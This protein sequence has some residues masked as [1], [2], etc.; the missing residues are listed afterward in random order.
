MLS[1]DK[2]IHYLLTCVWVL[3]LTQDIRAQ[4]SDSEYT[5]KLNFLKE[6]SKGILADYS[7]RKEKFEKNFNEQLKAF[8]NS[9]EDLAKKRFFMEE[10]RQKRTQLLESFKSDMAL[11]NE[12]EAELRAMRTPSDESGPTP[13]ELK[14]Q[15]QSQLIQ[16]RKSM[17]DFSE[18]IR[19]QEEAIQAENKKMGPEKEQGINQDDSVQSPP[20]AKPKDVP[21]EIQPKVIIPVNNPSTSTKKKY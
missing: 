18:R 3:F 10:A 2:R 8:G 20:Q 5:Q 7:A 9:K 16:D 12:Q 13:E 17:D 19:Q 11:I 1:N 14:M 6:K 21:R 4:I 15:F